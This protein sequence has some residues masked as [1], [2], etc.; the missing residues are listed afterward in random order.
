[1]V[2]VQ[3]TIRRHPTG[4]GTKEPYPTG[5]T[6]YGLSVDAKYTLLQRV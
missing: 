1:M 3:L 5:S 6:F 4:T 2:F